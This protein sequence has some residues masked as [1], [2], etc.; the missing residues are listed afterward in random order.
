DLLDRPGADF[1]EGVGGVEDLLEQRP[2]QAV[3]R[4]EVAKLTL[5]VQLQRGLGGGHGQSQSAG[6]I[7]SS[8]A[9]GAG[10]SNFTRSPGA[11][12]RVAPTTSGRIGSSRASR[13][14]RQ[15]RLMLA[16]RP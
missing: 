11:S 2:G 1:E 4:Q 3:E 10:P 9:S 5:F 12:D 7:G 15:T 8:R 13:S 16:G 14:S 6:R